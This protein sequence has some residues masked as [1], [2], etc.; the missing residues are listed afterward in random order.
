MVAGQQAGVAVGLK[1]HCYKY[2]YT[3]Y[4]VKVTVMYLVTEVAQ[5]GVP[6]PLRLLLCVSLHLLSTVGLLQVQ[7][8]PHVRVAGGEHAP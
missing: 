8:W 4:A 3:V 7:P 2:K 1:C 5:E 6:L